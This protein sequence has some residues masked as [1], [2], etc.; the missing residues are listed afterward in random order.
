MTTPTPPNPPVPGGDPQP[1]TAIPQTPPT[2]PAYGGSAPTPGSAASGGADTPGT[3]APVPGDHG[4]NKSLPWQIATGVLALTT[5]GFAIWGFNTNSTLNN[6][7]SST[8]QQI[9]A[10]QQQLKQLEATS[11][12]KEA[13]EAKEIAKYR[14]ESKKYKGDLKIDTSKIKQE[15]AEIAALNKKYQQAQANAQAK[16]NNLAAQLKA[17]QAESALAKKCASVMANGLL[18]IYEDVAT[19]VTYKEVDS[20]LKEASA[21]CGDV[22]TVTVP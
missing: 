11:G 20:V 4:K 16:E 8:D 15:T 12:A 1:T 3:P 13:A 21:T 10:L 7:Q 9:A 2:G 18:K 17:S 6:L 19:V 22:I 5:I 14:A